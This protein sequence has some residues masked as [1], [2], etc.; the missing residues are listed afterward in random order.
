M[1]NTRYTTPTD[2]MIG[3][4]TKS[5]E[6]GQYDWGQTQKSSDDSIRKLKAELYRSLNEKKLPDEK[7]KIIQKAFR[8]RNNKTQKKE[9][10]RKKSPSLSSDDEVA[11][12]SEIRGFTPIGMTSK[13]SSEPSL[14][15]LDKEVVKPIKKKVRSQDDLVRL[16]QRIDEDSTNNTPSKRLAKDL[17]KITFENYHK[18]REQRGGNPR[19]VYYNNVINNLKARNEELNENITELENKIKKEYLETIFIGKHP[20]SELLD[21]HYKELDK[22]YNETL[23]KELLELE[24]N[25]HKITFYESLKRG[26]EKNDTSVPYQD[27]RFQRDARLLESKLRKEI[28]R[29][30]E[31]LEE[32]FP[33]HPP[34]NGGKKKSRRK[35]RKSGRKT[36]R[37]K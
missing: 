13:S 10:K 7:A 9:K 3:S 23:K 22:L 26:I 32:R 4:V 36:K 37:K 21:E 20:P 30:Y 35:L 25:S 8:K 18:Q 17:D 28:E 34:S 5:G 16:A 12:I 14:Y 31:L 29:A 27:T 33:P 1:I 19:A 15:N 11:D 24:E 6:E 2:N